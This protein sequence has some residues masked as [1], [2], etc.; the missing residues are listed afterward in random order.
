LQTLQLRGALHRSPQRLTASDLAPGTSPLSLIIEAI[1]VFWRPTGVPSDAN[2]TGHACCPSPRQTTTAREIMRFGI[3]LLGD[4]VAPRCTFADAVL[5]VTTKRRRIQGQAVVPLD[6]NTWA[7]LATVLSEHRVDTLVCG[8]ISRSTRE[9]IDARDVA[10]IDNVAGTCEEILEA[11]RKE[12]IHPGFGLSPT[13]TA[14]ERGER[15]RWNAGAAATLTHGEA[16]SPRGTEATARTSVDCL[17]CGD[18][19]CL[20]GEPCPH[21]SVQSMDALTDESRRILEAAW[22]VA[23]EKERTLCRLAEVVYFALE[24]GYRKVGVAF[25]VDLEEPTAIL[26]GVLRRFFDVVPV[27]CRV[28]GIVPPGE[29]ESTA[30][31]PGGET[32]CDP[33]G[34]ACV[35]NDAKT[36]VNVVV[37]VC[38]GADCVFNRESK[39]PVTALFVKDK[40]LANNPIGAVYSHYHL[41]DI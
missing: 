21:T 2:E 31:A 34:M 23:L 20:W 38:V 25:C 24:M 22:D 3:P 27:C 29:G 39:A 9:S 12:R 36:D 18:R 16:G 41:E 10:I 40:S 37:G 6:G 33:S 8:G 11:L 7:D 15:R 19:V 35:L 30:S 28:G 5:V 4:R 17:E 1:R 13:R 32:V 14:G 26:T